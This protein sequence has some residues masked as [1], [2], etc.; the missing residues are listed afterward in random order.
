L[1]KIKPIADESLGVRSMAILVEVGD[2]NILLDAGVSL[3][4]SRYGLPPHPA[5]FKELIRRR[6]LLL[7]AA[8]RASIVVVSHYHRDHYTP[9]ERRIYEAS[10]P[11][12]F[13]EIYGG[14]LVLAAN[15]EI[16]LTG[17]Q[18]Q[19]A[20]RFF[21]HAERI[22]RLRLVGEGDSVAVGD[23]VL[24]FR[25]FSHGEGR[26]GNVL[27]VVIRE[28]GVPLLIYAPDVQGP[29][30]ERDA[31]F[32]LDNIPRLLV[33]GGPPLYLARSGR[34]SWGTVERGMRNL[35]RIVAS[36]HEAG[37]KVVLSHHLL[38]DA[39]WRQELEKYGIRE[40]FLLYS[41]LCGEEPMFLEAYRRDLYEAEPP[42]AGYIESISRMKD[43]RP[44]DVLRE[45]R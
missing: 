32:I 41:D 6:K 1:E 34:V 28:E 19:R 18:K 9:F 30:K 42:P 20:R 36:V 3:A 29:F 5:E 4:P 15:P 27:G 40:G 21:S 22:S 2:T 7:N 33:I 25:V 11:D 45:K 17:S 44:E 38:R 39:E 43:A 14:K 24:E 26:M 16:G 10:G 8:G 35:S 37:G 13:R 12:V 23:V 31:S